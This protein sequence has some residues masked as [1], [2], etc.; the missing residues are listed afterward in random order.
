MTFLA[1]LWSLSLVLVALS[2]ALMGGLIVRRAWLNQRAS[3][4]ESHR[5]SITRTILGYLDETCSLDDVKRDASASS[6]PLSDL[7]RDLLLL[8]RGDDRARLIA[9][10]VDLEVPRQYIDRLRR[11]SRH[12]RAGA[13]E[14]LRLFDDPDVVGA[15]TA[16]LDDSNAQVRL[17]AAGSLAELGACP[18]VATLVVKLRVGTTER[19]W[20]LR[21]IFRGLVGSRLDEVAR[22]LSDGS[23]PFVK[24]LALDALGRS[25]DYR[26]VHMIAPLVSDA[27]AEL[28]TAAL[29]ALA[30]LGHP[31]AQPLVERAFGDEDGAVRTQAAVSAGRIGLIGL[32]PMLA[33][34]VDDHN[35]W[36]RFRAAEALYVLGQKGRQTLAALAEHGSPR[37]REMASQVLAEKSA[38]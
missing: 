32:T 9:L 26:V 3:Q 4:L 18:P 35:W 10:L 6:F 34:L 19:S 25:A 36:T 31:A 11:G 29:R 13:A 8:V 20:A 16:A 15:L 38:A 22:L 21:R 12:E 23:S 27:N 37:A 30:T 14:A 24:A 33:Q 5:R 17:A 1:W 2:L 7:V 28:R